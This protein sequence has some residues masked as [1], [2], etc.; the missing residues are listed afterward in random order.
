MKCNN[1][2]NFLEKKFISCFY[3]IAVSSLKKTAYINISDLAFYME[4]A[5]SVE[6]LILL[7]F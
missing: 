2:C 4:L 1:L 5:V 6:K 3:L 7:G